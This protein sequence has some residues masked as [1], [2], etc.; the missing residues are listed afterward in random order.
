MTRMKT[1]QNLER[2]YG[3]TL[4]QSVRML[5]AEGLDPVSASATMLDLIKEDFLRIGP[6]YILE[7]GSHV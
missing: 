6:E 1:I 2:F 5:E 3:M 4:R 7:E